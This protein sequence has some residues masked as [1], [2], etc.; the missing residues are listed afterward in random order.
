MQNGIYAAAV[1]PH[2][3][4]GHEADFGAMLELVD[5]ISRAGVQGVCL[6]GPAG[7][8]W[9]TAPGLDVPSGV[10][11]AAVRPDRAAAP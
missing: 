5:F 6:L 1:T 8:V 3:R 9:P 11:R 10:V 2:R 4:E 7:E